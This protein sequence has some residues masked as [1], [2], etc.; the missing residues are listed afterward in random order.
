M[1]KSLVLALV[2]AA[3]S[4]SASILGVLVKSEPTTTVTGQLAW[5]CTYSV[6]GQYTTIILREMCPVS[7]QFE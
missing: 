5:R 4:A 7:M 6:A 1:H 3:S 2:V